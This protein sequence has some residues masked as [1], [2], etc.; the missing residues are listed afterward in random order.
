MIVA[1]NFFDK[2]TTLL[3]RDLLGCFIVR[4]INGETIAGRIVETESYLCDDP[5]CH[6][7]GGRRTR[8]TEVLFSAPGKAYIYLI[9]GMYYCLNV[10]SAPEGV[11]EAV[12]IR[13]LEPVKGLDIMMERRG[14]ADAKNL[15]SGPGKLA[16]ALGVTREQNG[17]DLRRGE[18]TLHTPESFKGF[19]KPA[20]RDIVT[21]TR[22]GLNVAADLPLRFYIRGNEFISK[23]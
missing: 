13:A 10:T 6:A 22:I 7:Y 12:L 16:Q 1:K 18:L 11:G 2:P 4:T 9:Y 23:K 8:R 17:L 14:T 19:A 15:C 20:A 21:T 5:A 3:A